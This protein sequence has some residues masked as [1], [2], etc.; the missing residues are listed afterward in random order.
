M[1]GNDGKHAGSW[2]SSSKV[3]HWGMT[4]GPVV[5]FNLTQRGENDILVLSPFSRNYLGYYTDN[6]AYYYGHTE[7]GRNYEETLVDIRHKIGLP[8][9][10][11]QLDSWWYYRGIGGGVSNWTARSDIFP[12]GLPIVYRRLENLPFVV[13]NRYWAYDN[14]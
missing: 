8:I 7:Q 4:G 11:I 1:T 14:V 2:N 6:G 9:H 13:H 12:D 5:I 3:V 10:Y